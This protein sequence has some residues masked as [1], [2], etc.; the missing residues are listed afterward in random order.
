M[1][2]VARGPASVGLTGLNLRPAAPTVWLCKGTLYQRKQARSRHSRNLLFKVKLCSHHSTRPTEQHQRHR[3]EE[4]GAHS[5]VLGGRLTG[6]GGHQGKGCLTFLSFKFTCLSDLF[7]INMLLC[8]ASLYFS[9]RNLKQPEERNRQTSPLRTGA[10]GGGMRFTH[11]SF[12]HHSV[13]HDNAPALLLPHHLPE[14][15]AGVG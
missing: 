5:P 2:G 1:K 11:R 12:L 9:N 3:G 6:W 10:A 8:T 7:T 15:A 4:S 14:V 13:E